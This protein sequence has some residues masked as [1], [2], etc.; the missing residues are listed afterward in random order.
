MHNGLR[1]KQ[2]VDRLTNYELDDLAHV[3]E[4]S[5]G[6]HGIPRKLLHIFA[7]KLN[8]IQLSRVPKSFGREATRDAIG[9]MAPSKLDEFDRISSGLVLENRPISLRIGDRPR[10]VKVSNMGQFLT[11]TPYE[12]YL[13]FRTAPV[14]SLGVMGA[15][16]E[17]ATV[18]SKTLIPAYY[19]GYAIG[20]YVVYPLLER[21]ALASIDWLGS[22]IAS[23]V[24]RLSNSWT[25]APSVTAQV[26]QSTATSFRCTSTQ[27]NYF[28]SM[29]GDYGV[30]DEWMEYIGG[31]MYC[32]R[33]QSCIPIWPE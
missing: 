3:Y 7:T 10:L 8:P 2:L 4:A 11:Y 29:G 13:S 14:G 9:Y 26:Q 19:T 33:G 31:T 21:Y 25:S 17:T 23:I 1:P 20:T 32:P 24:D 15:L 18:L 12:V 30:A 22:S 27:I 5:T 28:S 16:W 6:Y